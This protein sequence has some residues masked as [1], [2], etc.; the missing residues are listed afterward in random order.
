M[1]QTQTERHSTNPRLVRMSLSWKRQT[2]KLV[3]RE[4]G[5]RVRTV[6]AKGDAG[7]DPGPPSPAPLF[8]VK[9]LCWDS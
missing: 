2:E 7:L 6:K 9:G 4:E 8:I 1:R 5:A 3:H